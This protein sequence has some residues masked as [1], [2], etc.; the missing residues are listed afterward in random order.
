MDRDGRLAEG[1]DLIDPPELHEALDRS[2]Q[3]GPDAIGLGLRIEGEPPVTLV[4]VLEVSLREEL[5]EAFAV[6][7]LLVAAAQGHADDQY[8]ADDQSDD[9]QAENFHG[10]LARFEPSSGESRRR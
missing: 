5:V 3:V 4:G 1:V 10:S 6:A 9:D 7:G 8:R 2:P